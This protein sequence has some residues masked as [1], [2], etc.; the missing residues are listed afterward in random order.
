MI[1]DDL[2]ASPVRLREE[3]RKL[4]ALVPENE[5]ALDMAPRDLV[6]GAISWH[7]CPL[8][9]TGAGCACTGHCRQYAEEMLK[10]MEAAGFVFARVDLTPSIQIGEPRSE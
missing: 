8:R 10:D 7:F 6:L 9:G 1:E 2:S 5:R 3:I 4:R